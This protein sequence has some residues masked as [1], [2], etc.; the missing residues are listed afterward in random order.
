MLCKP[1]E[2][3]E[4]ERKGGGVVSR[5]QIQNK[6]STFSIDKC[7]FFYFRYET[8]IETTVSDQNEF[9]LLEVIK[10]L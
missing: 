8:I 4:R 2:E 6:F 3:R 9:S 10:S 1:L 5:N 7:Y